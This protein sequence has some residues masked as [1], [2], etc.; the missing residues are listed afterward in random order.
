MTTFFISRH[1]GAIEWAAR[2]HMPVDRCLAHL[3]PAIVMAGDIVIG[4]LPVNLAAQVCAAGAQYWHLSLEL[5][6]EMRGQE[7]SADDMARLGARV[8]RFDVRVQ[9]MPDAPPSK[10]CQ[11]GIKT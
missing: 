4:S 2:Q 5:P 3:D 7:L 1:P 8:E 10:Q 11:L 6:A 9:P